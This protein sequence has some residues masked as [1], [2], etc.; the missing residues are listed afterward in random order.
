M[1]NR[2]MRAIRAADGLYRKLFGVMSEEE[3]NRKWQILVPRREKQGRTDA[4][5]VAQ[6]V[7]ATEPERSAGSAE[8]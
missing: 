4:E 6:I 5:I 3:A 1:E 7:R 8:A 2:L